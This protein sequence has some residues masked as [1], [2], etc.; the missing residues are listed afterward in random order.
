[1]QHFFDAD[2]RKVPNHLA[3]TPARGKHSGMASQ[4]TKNGEVFCD[5][6]PSSIHPIPSIR[7]ECWQD[8]ILVTT[9]PVPSVPT[10]VFGLLIPGK[11]SIPFKY[12]R[13]KIGIE[14]WEIEGQ[15]LF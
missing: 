15:L 11:T 3:F 13:S 2:K 12:H 1:M 9:K 8:C 14:G 6:I 10:D 7:E 5:L 4:L